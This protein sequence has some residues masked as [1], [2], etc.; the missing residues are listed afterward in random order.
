[1]PSMDPPCISRKKGT[2][3]EHGCEPCAEPIIQLQVLRTR[4]RVP[5]E[6]RKPGNNCMQKHTDGKTSLKRIAALYRAKALKMAQHRWMRP[7]NSSE[8]SF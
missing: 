7:Q 2:G 4:W 5:L 8:I 6:A 3:P 1:M